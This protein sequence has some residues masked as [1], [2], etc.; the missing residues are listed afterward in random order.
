[1]SSDF[2]N[3]TLGQLGPGVAVVSDSIVFGWYDFGSEV[4]TLFC[5]DLSTLTKRWEW[6]IPWRWHERSVRPTVTTLADQSRAYAAAVGKYGDNLF[7]FRLSDGALLW[8][9]TVEKFPAEAALALAGDRLLVRSKLWGWAPDPHEQLDA[10]HIVDGRGLWRTWLTGEAKYYVGP[11]LIQGDVV[12]TTTRAS[13]RRGNLFAVRLTD[14]HTTRTEIP[15]AGAPF[16]AHR[17]IVYLGGLP[18]AAYDVR[19]GRTLWQSSVGHAER[20]SIPMIAGGA[21]DPVRKILYTGDSQRYLYALRAGD[22]AVVQRIRIDTYSRFELFS[23]LKALFA[24]YGVR[25]V[26]IDSAHVLVGTVDSSL[27]VF[28]ADA[29][30]PASR[31]DRLREASST[32]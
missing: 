12:L 20:D 27:F 1:M 28:R 15:T 3:I 18:P 13:E 22:G 31:D 10:V 29:L 7:A 23:P 2:G 17:D 26:A 30:Q 5:F 21:F 14:G 19:S 4:G 11:P 16:A 24:S 32:K 6:R 25:R 9:R 8:N